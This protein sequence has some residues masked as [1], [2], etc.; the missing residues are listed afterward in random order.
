MAL[1]G[2]QAYKKFIGD[3]LIAFALYNQVAHHGFLFAEFGQNGFV[4]PFSLLK[5]HVTQK[6]DKEDQADVHP[7]A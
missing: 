6:C 5:Y 4:L 3:F 7:P 2:A 1:Y